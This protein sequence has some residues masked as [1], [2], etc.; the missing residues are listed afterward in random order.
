MK[1]SIEDGFFKVANA[2]QDAICCH[3][4]TARE[5]SVLNCLIRCTYGWR[6]KWTRP[7]VTQ[8]FLAV[9]SGIERPHVSASLKSLIA[10]KVILRDGRSYAINTNTSQWEV[11]KPGAT[12]AEALSKS[13]PNRYG[14]TAKLEKPRTKSV[15]KCSSKPYS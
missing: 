15:R 8:D 14:K 3:R 2:M 5:G 4:F 1:V 9:M 13:V 12:Y 7:E 6:T 10:A 11:P